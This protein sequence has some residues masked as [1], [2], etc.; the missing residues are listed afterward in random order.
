MIF[1]FEK[2]GYQIV[3][4]INSGSIHVVDPLI[5]QLI[6]DYPNPEE[7]K[8]IDRY[9]D[10]PEYDE[11]IVK[12][13]LKEINQLIEKNLLFSEKPK[14]PYQFNH[15]VK[16]L[17]LHIAHDCNIRCE[18]C[19]AAQG[20]FKGDNLL[21]N[22]EVG[23][24]AID[25][26][27]KNSGNRR[28]LEVDFFGGEPLLNFDVVKHLVFYGK[29]KAKFHHKN[30]RFTITTNGTLLNE[31]NR[32][33]INEHMANVV[34]S[35]DGTKE[36]NDR[37]RYYANKKGT[38]EDILPKLQLMVEERGEKDYYLRGTFTKYNVD[39]AKDVLHFS[40]L[41][42]KNLSIEPVVADKTEQYA[43]TEE[44]LPKIFEEYDKLEE[45]YFQRLNTDKTFEFFHFKFNLESNPC[46]EKRALGCGAG[47]E[48]L[49][50]TPEGDFYP[51]HQFAGDPNF[52]MGNVIKGQELDQNICSVFKNANVEKK[53]ECSKCWAKYYCSGG[54]H[55]NA[56]NENQDLMKPYELGCEMEKKRIQNSI[57]IEVKKRMGANTL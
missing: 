15:V 52:K 3:L 51:C 22:N 44:D 7:E 29:E 35:I 16:A 20:N 50:V 25:F 4:D 48:Y 45:A 36:T 47:V 5:Y 41:G 53:A 11:Q 54:C 12:L 49:S 1:K 40:D 6:D 30:L 17:C 43:L 21:M 14:K 10:H 26:L 31:E 24:K 27:I 46:Q 33:F 32:K 2:D 18:Y 38:Y 37:M 19:F 34:L 9:K 13:G 56:Y 42:F 23:E 28:N 55:A 57:I 39:F 8:L